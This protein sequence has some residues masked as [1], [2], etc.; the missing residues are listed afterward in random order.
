MYLDKNAQQSGS[1]SLSSTSGLEDQAE[2]EMEMEIS[3]QSI[4]FKRGH[5]KY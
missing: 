3:R 4:K 2:R 1:S 5:G